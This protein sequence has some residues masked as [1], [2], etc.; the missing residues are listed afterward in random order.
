MDL[1]LEGRYQRERVTTSYQ[2]VP[3]TTS[4]FKS[5]IPRVILTYKPTDEMTTYASWAR[6]SLPGTDNSIVPLLSPALQAT[7]QAAPGYTVAVPAETVQNFE[8]GV[9]Q[10]SARFR[11]A[12]T[13]YFMKWNNLKNRVSYACPGNQC[14]PTVVNATVNVTLA[15]TAKIYGVEAEVGAV[16]TDAWDVNASFDYVHGR[17]DRFFQPLTI[18]HTGQSNAA[19]KTIL[20]F[21][22]AQ[23][24]VTTTYRGTFS[25]PDWSWYTRAGMT[26]S[27]K[28]YVE[29]VNQSWIAGSARVNLH[30]GIEHGQSKIDFYVDN[31]TDNRQWIGGLRALQ[32]NYTVGTV[33]A[34]QATATMVLPRLRTFGVR[35]STKFN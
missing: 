27:G 26:Y 34:S 22:E 33:V 11:Y 28:I 10:Q 13:G 14:G 17:Y 31:L 25:N 21:P 1:D 9:K 18:Q 32:S 3:Q 2:L 20:G 15:Q 30:A 35:I 8:L 24:A 12:L 16:L 29:E 6:G 5:F 4:A 19:G 23:A 7:V